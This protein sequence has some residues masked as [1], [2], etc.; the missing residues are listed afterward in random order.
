[1]LHR[2]GAVVVCRGL[3][4]GR[5]FNVYTHGAMGNDRRFSVHA[6][7]RALLAASWLPRLLREECDLYVVRIGTDHMQRPYKLSR[8][9]ANCECMIEAFGIRRVYFTTNDEFDIALKHHIA[10]NTRPMRM[11]MTILHPMVGGE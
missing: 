3:I 8:P 2:L 1:M 10:H 6:E 7:V 9:C 5:G 4:V 11:T